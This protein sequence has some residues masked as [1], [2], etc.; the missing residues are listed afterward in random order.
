MI[1]IGRGRNEIEPFVKSARRIILG[2]HR[3]GAQAGDLRRLVGPLDSILQHPF[4]EALPLPG[5][6]D[7][8]AG[9]QHDGDRMTGNSLGQALRC[10]GIFD[11][12]ES[13]RI[14]THDF[15]V[16]KGD[17]SLRGVGLLVR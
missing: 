12:A 2:M 15:G 17:I 10:V 5:R 8:E 3:H 7:R 9:Q 6:A 11:L 1:R 14:V 16:S 4:A 13:E